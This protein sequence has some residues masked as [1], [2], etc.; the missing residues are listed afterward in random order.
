MARPA[1]H[2]EREPL[3]AMLCSAVEVY[4][5]ECFGFMFGRTPT[6]QRAHYI[7]G[8]CFNCAALSRRTSTTTAQ[9]V[10][11]ARRLFAL[12]DSAP[13]LYPY[14]G[15]YHSHTGRTPNWQR[16]G[17]S[18]TDA[19]NMSDSDAFG[20]VIT[21]RPRG[22]RCLVWRI[23]SVHTRLRGSLGAFD[24][25]LTAH[26]LVKDEAG[27]YVKDEAGHWK[28]ERLRIDVSASTLCALNRM[29]P[30]PRT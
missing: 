16:F 27:D 9:S 15:F 2:I 29:S 24:F 3:L 18:S 25:H 30:R 21:V 20:V 22:P 23:R 12:T 28:S 10:P 8:S 11:A 26:A 13:R 17:F 5:R 1:V 4:P 14:L 19:M 6:R 7:L